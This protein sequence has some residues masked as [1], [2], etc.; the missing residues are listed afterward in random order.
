MKHAGL[1][2]NDSWN[3]LEMGSYKPLRGPK[4]Q[5]VVILEELTR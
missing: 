5:T 4:R 2:R 3:W 1:I